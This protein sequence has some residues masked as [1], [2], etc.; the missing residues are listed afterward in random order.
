M[1]LPMYLATHNAFQTS[2]LSLDQ[3]GRCDC[4]STYPL[5]SIGTTVSR[6]IAPE[7]IAIIF[8]HHGLLPEPVDS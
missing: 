3:E 1:S 7:T 6:K 5:V 2:P 8:I 4:S